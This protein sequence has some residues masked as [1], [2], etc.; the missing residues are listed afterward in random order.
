MGPDRKGPNGEPLGID[1]WVDW[2]ASNG[3][4]FA[5]P[6]WA[7]RDGVVRGPAPPWPAVASGRRPT[8]EEPDPWVRDH[9]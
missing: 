6:E 1:A 2:V 9:C 3:V 5:V 4:P 7:I 8:T